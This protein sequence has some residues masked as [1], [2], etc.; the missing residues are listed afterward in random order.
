[1]TANSDWYRRTTWTEDDQ[2]AFFTR[3]VASGSTFHKAQYTRLQAVT[4]LET[5]DPMWREAAR[6]L[7]E[8]VIREYPHEESQ[9]LLAHVGRAE[10]LTDAGDRPATAEALVGAL[11]A[12]AKSP[13]W[14]ATALL[15]AGRIAVRDRLESVYPELDTVLSALLGGLAFQL[16]ADRY[17]AAYVLAFIAEHDGDADRARAYAKMALRYAAQ[18]TPMVPRFPGLGTVRQASPVVHERLLR[19]AADA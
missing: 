15:T 19:L 12:Y 17:V 9:L 6:A 8:F 7:F 3:L 4:L 10:C 11:A 2:R 18:R 13:G 14:Y 16:P 5:G 1:M